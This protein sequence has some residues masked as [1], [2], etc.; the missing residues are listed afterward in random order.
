MSLLEKAWETREERVY[1]EILGK[2]QSGIYTL[3]GELFSEKFKQD[4]IDPRWLHIGIFEIPPTSKRNSWL[5]V[6]SGLSNPWED[7]EDEFSGIGIELVFETNSSAKWAISFLQ[8]M[9]AYNILLAAGRFGEQYSILSEGDRVPLRS[10]IDGSSDSAIQNTMVS[11]PDHFDKSFKLE[12]GQVDFLHFVGISD[13]ELAEAKKSSSAELL[14]KLK[15]A[16]AYPVTDPRRKSI[17]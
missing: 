6:S 3:P 13:A 10:S 7:R 17:L 5:Y 4:S 15:A 9:V 1:P 8:N 11:A 16:G 12:S 14:L 2:A